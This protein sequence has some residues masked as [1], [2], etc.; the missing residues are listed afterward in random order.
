[1]I[2]S[3]SSQVADKGNLPIGQIRK[4]TSITLI[5]PKKESQ[6]LRQIKIHFVCVIDEKTPTWKSKQLLRNSA[7]RKTKMC[8]KY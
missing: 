8:E 4:K 5:A 7:D 1:M 6:Q 2:S 3:T